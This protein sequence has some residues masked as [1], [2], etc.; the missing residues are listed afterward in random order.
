ME[1]AAD[2][3]PTDSLPRRGEREDIRQR[4][5]GKRIHGGNRR[6]AAMLRPDSVQGTSPFEG[7]YTLGGGPQCVSAMLAG[8]ELKKL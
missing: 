2:R 8:A 6:G 4:T 1:C 5:V 3:C 7:A